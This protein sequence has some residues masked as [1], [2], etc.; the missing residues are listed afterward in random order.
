MMMTKKTIAIA[1]IHGRAD[2]LEAIHRFIA[3]HASADSVDPQIIYLGDICDRGP[4]SK[5][6]FNMVQRTLKNFAS[7]VFIRGNHDNW[8]LRS[9]RYGEERAKTNWIGK[10]GTATLD[11]YYLGESR[12]AMDI[13]DEFH[14]DHLDLVEDAAT[15]V[16]R[17]NVCF[18]HAGI[19][20]GKAIAD[21]DP[22]DMM[23]VRED[24]LDHVGHLEK[25]VVHGHTH[26]GTLPVVTENRIS[27]DTDAN[28]TGRLTALV[29]DWE[30]K[31]VRF[32]QTDGSAASVIEVQPVLKNRGLGVATDFIFEDAAIA[33]AA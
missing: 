2:L 12:E 14:Q 23:W 26:I 5:K 11:S 29:I 10:G 30:E 32:F 6:C 4:H 16:I 25:V 15:H 22:Y 7:S 31:T 20:P 28:Q 21:Q 3:D 24:F 13:I 17:E 8:F 27:L 9:V 18:T 1:D 33:K 19:M